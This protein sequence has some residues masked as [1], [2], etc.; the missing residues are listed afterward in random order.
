MLYYHLLR[1]DQPVIVQPNGIK[2]KPDKMIV[3]KLYHCIFEDKLFLFYK[4][5]QQL[6]H[7]Y[8]VEEAAAVKEISENP[9]NIGSIL[10]RYAVREKEEEGI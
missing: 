3:E 10:T 4:D 1:L 5:E 6:L 7:C 2:L 9:D 8:E